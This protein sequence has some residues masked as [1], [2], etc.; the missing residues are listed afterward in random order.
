M[1]KEKLSDIISKKVLYIVFAVIGVL[2]G[3]FSVV[4]LI[5]EHGIYSN[6]VWYMLTVLWFLLAGFF[7][8]EYVKAVKNE[9]KEAQMI[10]DFKEKYRQHHTN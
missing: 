9:K 8:Y 3:A 4:L 10:A 7:V 1:E 5:V 2:A 6:G